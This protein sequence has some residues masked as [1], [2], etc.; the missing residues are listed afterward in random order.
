MLTL[1][2]L[3]NNLS[4]YEPKSRIII[5]LQVRS[6]KLFEEGFT[7]Y[8]T[9]TIYVGKVSD[10]PPTKIFTAQVNLLLLK[11]SELPFTFYEN[12]LIN[13][14]LIED[15]HQIIKIINDLQDFFNTREFIAKAIKKL[16]AIVM[17]KA[18][19]QE[20]LE[21]AHQL[22]GNP[23]TLTDSTHHLVAHAG[24]GSELDEPE[25]QHYLEHG[26]MSNRFAIAVGNDLEFRRKANSDIIIPLVIQ[27]EDILKHP[28]MVGRVTA[29]GTNIAY[30]AM[31]E[32]NRPFTETDYEL[33]PIVCDFISI[34]MQQSQDKL[35]VATSETESMIINLLNGTY[36]PR[37]AHK[38]THSHQLKL[39]DELCIICISVDEVVDSTDKTV[40]V[41]S[42][43]QNFFV[44]SITVI[45]NGSVVIINEYRHRDQLF[46]SKDK[47]SA[48][49]QLL[50]AHNLRAG[51]SRPFYHLSDIKQHF[52]QAQ[53]AI[54]TASQLAPEECLYFY[55]EYFFHYLV[56]RL[57]ENDSI[58]SIC[59]PKFLQLIKRDHEKASSYAL[60]LYL[61]LQNNGD[62][63]ATAQAMHLHYNTM[64]YRLQR[65]S[66]MMDVDLNNYD[67]LLKC[68]LYFLALEN[69][70]KIAF[71]DYFNQVRIPEETPYLEK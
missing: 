53:N 20:M 59:H 27:Y 16:L 40:L 18:D 21:T 22:L 54:N 52:Q 29:E 62:I 23:L 10:L 13:Y 58:A 57:L 33:V 4:K 24:W 43:M 30:L 31:L 65:I 14:I 28:Q 6:F 70:H 41:K 67:I 50:L 66:D 12:P 49:K 11:D 1:Q 25:W 60:S 32:V 2:K 35:N 56:T 7:H 8:A 47:T 42:L 36:D 63:K 51:V 44:G 19:L 34:L 17:K 5:D 69:Y 48:F 45:Y 3:V 15:Q 55:E 71:T 38:K 64:K 9:D 37:T 39:A 68:K 61:Y 46:F 26:F